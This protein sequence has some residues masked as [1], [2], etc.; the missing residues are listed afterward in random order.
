MPDLPFGRGELDSVESIFDIFLLLFEWLK[1]R[2]GHVL[3]LNSGFT[4]GFETARREFR[5]LCERRR[6]ADEEF[7]DRGELSSE[8]KR[9]IIGLLGRI[10]G[11]TAPAELYGALIA[12]D[13]AFPPRPIQVRAPLNRQFRERGEVRHLSG[14]RRLPYERQ[15]YVRGY[16]TVGSRIE[17][18]LGSLTVCLR[19]ASD[20]SIEPVV[21]DDYVLALFEDRPSPRVGIAPFVASS[22]QPVIEPTDPVPGSRPFFRAAGTDDPS[23]FARLTV[24]L[25]RATKEKTD[26][27]LFP[28]LSFTRALLHQLQNE[29]ED[30]H[31]AAPIIKLVIAGTLRDDE[32][33]VCHVLGP[34]GAVLW[35]QP[36]M[37]RFVLEPGELRT[38]PEPIPELGGVEDIDI[39]D[40]AIRVADLPFGRL[41]VLVCLD[42]ILPETHSLLANMQVN[43]I[44]V[45]A[46]TRTRRRFETLAWAHA[47]ASQATTF[48]C[49]APNCPGFRAS[50]RS[51]VLTPLK[52]AKPLSIG[53]AQ[54]WERS[55][56]VFSAN[57]LLAK[58]LHV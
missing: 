1:R 6:S 39:S 21:V 10:A 37:N 22:E 43:C 14:D 25:D 35:Q 28:E 4:L 20:Y 5:G 47:A 3:T 19:P 33:N 57:P 36:K 12:I 32:R 8:G 13:D 15:D 55:M 29:L 9:E 16:A 58:T 27:L 45:P 17:N 51:F 11:G 40:R 56:L 50:A 18:K 2:E 44:F 53:K 54:P 24:L 31:R 34:D 49:N 42:F 7:A 38:A 48:F 23:V 41:A 26:I 52:G 30:R 46:M